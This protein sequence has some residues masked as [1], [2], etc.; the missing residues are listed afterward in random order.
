MSLFSRFFRKAPPPAAVPE[1]A[2]RVSRPNPEVVRTAPAPDR[3][4]AAAQ[5]EAILQ[6]AI[7]RN[8]SAAVA[9]LVVTGTSTKVRQLA[10]QAIEDPAQLRELIREVRGGNDKSVYKLLTSKRDAQL[11]EARKQAL[12]QEE[13]STAATAIERH[14]RR[15]YDALFGPTLDQLELRW[16]SVVANAS[17]ETA[18]TTREA[19]DRSREVIASH[20][21]QI[22]AEAS[23]QL[24]AQNAAAEALRL[25]E[26]EEKTT[27][28]EAAERA[29]IRDE[30]R[31]AEAEKQAVEAL[32]LR[33]L[34]GLIRKAL[35]AL[36]DGSTGRAAGLRRAIEEKLATTPPL[37]TYLTNQ[38]QNLDSRLNE[39]ED[40]KSF[41]VA[42]KRIELMQEMESL[43]DS[44]LEPPVLAERIKSLQE[45][46]RTLSK[47]A[48]ENHEEDWQRFQEASQKAYQPCR[49]YFADQAR[50]R[51]DNLQN[52]EALL[53]RLV[54]FESEHDWEQPEWRRVMTALRESKQEWR[55][56]TP[57]DRAP[58][59]V[60]QE[61]F[62]AVTSKLQTRL[63]AE[64]AANISRKQALIQ[65]TQQLLTATDI[66]QS[67]DEIK[68]LQRQWQAAGPVPRA[69]DHRLW[70]E[71]RQHCD[72]VFQRRQQELVEYTS[73]L[74][75]N[76]VQ[77]LAMCEELGTLAGLAGPLLHESGGRVAE[78][79]SA[80]GALGE[81]PR[82]D[83]RELHNRF[84][85]A[86]ESWEAAVARQRLRDSRQSWNDLLEA[87]D[88]VR[89]YRL[90][91]VRN[92]E[93]SE[94]DRLRRAAADYIASVPQWPKG[95]RE[96]I[97][98]AL[99]G[100]P[101]EDLE[102]N[103]RA[104][105]LLCVR[106]EILVDR[107]TPAADQGLRREYQ[108]QRLI[109]GMGQGIRDSAQLDTL[110]LEWLGVGPVEATVYG[111]LLERF[112]GCRP[113]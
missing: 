81:L 30:Q 88:R 33:Q 36:N 48:G 54:A 10:A 86:Y 16:N 1:E 110:T 44:T 4:A 92:D 83:A 45:E 2:Q 111:P 7:D 62:V 25:R 58:G 94:R 89:A 70:D 68:D 59:K 12:L 34:G 79:R 112:T 9:R 77:A 63:D 104:L 90:T 11:A 35:S 46:W 72:A 106:A 13:V 47:G 20:L 5:E 19:I 95:G 15:P 87:A 22:A 24:A 3:A 96:A 109:Q 102:A 8:D 105:R 32:A 49:E 64:Y 18:A 26:L 23:R 39:L 74:E 55:Q 37:S 101:G 76:K 100:L 91:L 97:N 107:P 56:H 65:R 40:W 61:Q 84:E 50:V 82:S 21:R 31:K 73:A 53:A 99:D 51:Q 27:A 80:F 71:F 17:A 14:S 85:R 57:V 108:V 28:A 69:E 113:H 98:L 38:L 41:S 52:R 43:A 6:A 103:E 60:L 78:L 75:A 42:P 66:R 29:R 67:I 93:Q